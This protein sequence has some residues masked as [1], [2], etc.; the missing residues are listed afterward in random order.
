MKRWLVSLS[1]P[2]LIIFFLLL[3]AVGGKNWGFSFFFFLTFLYLNLFIGVFSLSF[4]GRERKSFAFSLVSFL[5]GLAGGLAFPL[6]YFRQSVYI[7]PQSDLLFFLLLVPIFTLFF[8]PIFK[9]LSIFPNKSL[10][11]ENTPFFSSF[12]LLI[13]S[14]FLGLI[15]AV[16][17]L[18]SLERPSSFAPLVRFVH[19]EVFPLISSVLW[20]FSLTCFIACGEGRKGREVSLS[21]LVGLGIGGLVFSFFWHITSQGFKFFFSKSFLFLPFLLSLILICLYFL[22]RFSLLEKEFFFSRFYFAYF[23]PLLMVLV[24]AP[25][26][27]LKSSFLFSPLVLEG[28]VGGGFLF[29]AGFFLIL[30][31]EGLKVSP[32]LAMVGLATVL[33]LFSLIV[34]FLPYYSY[35]VSGRPGSGINFSENWTSPGYEFVVPWVFFLAGLSGFLA[36]RVG[37]IDLLKVFL[38]FLSLSFSVPLLHKT[39]LFNW[40]NFLPPEVSEALG[41]EYLN[42]GEKPVYS[43]YFY[44]AFYIITL[45]AFVSLVYLGVESRRDKRK[46]GSD[47]F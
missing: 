9:K 13:L 20:S 4:F 16:A 45:L 6:F 42:W 34:L 38:S 31:K 15:S 43:F 8:I 28:L 35:Q 46:E 21:W 44:F 37:K 22:L 18:S 39:R 26:E 24:F 14:Y 33:T 32:R 25:L 3:S 47:E 11:D 10:E 23:A 5:S 2:F 7:P 29:L 30:I 27:R 36:A 17:V 12:S 41:T 19:L 1:W 40:F